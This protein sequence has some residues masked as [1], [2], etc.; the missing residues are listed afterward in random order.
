VFTRTN[1]LRPLVLLMFAALA[2]SVMMGVVLASPAQAETFTVA[3]TNDSGADSLRQAILDANATTDVDKIIFAQDLSGQTIPLAS[4]LPIIAPKS[5]FGALTI[6]A[7]SADITISGDDGVGG[8]VRVF[9]VGSLAELT[10]NN[11]T[12]AN[13]DADAGGGILNFG[14]LTVSNSTLSG[15]SAFMGFGG[16]IYNAGPDSTLTVN[17]STFSRNS[18]T[19]QGGGIGNF[20]GSLEVNNSTF[21]DNS[22][23][24]GGGGIFNA[25][26]ATL[27]NTIVANSPSG[28]NCSGVIVG[29]GNLEWPGNTCG[30][31]F[32][33]G[34]PL[35]GPLADNGGPTQ[36]H[37]LQ[38]GSAAID[39]AVSCPPPATDQRNISRPQGPACDIGSFEFDEP[40]SVKIDQAS[41]QAD[42]T[43]ASPI[44]FTA[45]FNE[46]VTGFTDSDVT[47]SGTAKPT[48]AVVSG[49]PTTFDIAVSGMSSSGTVIASIPANS[50]Q[51]TTGNGNSAST[52]TD[53]TVEFI[54]PNSP[55][56]AADD[57][58][59]TNEDTPLTE[60]APGVLGNDSDSDSGDTL[61][62]ELVS[63]P[64]H[65]TLTLDANGSFS[66]TPATNYHGPDSFTY[67]ATDG[68][69]GEDTATVNITVT[70]VND[71]PVLDAIGNKEVDEGQL[72]SFTAQAT[73]PDNDAISYS[74]VAGENCASGES[75]NVPSGASFDPNTGEFSW[76]PTEQQ[77][78]GTYKLKVKA[79]DNGSPNLSD[80]EQITITV[81]EVNV[82]PELASIGDK[83]VDE[84]QQLSFTAQATDADEPANNITYSLVVGDNC[85]NGETC[86]VPSGATINASTGEFS[87]TPDFTQAGTY[88]LKVKATDDGSPNLSAEEQI[89]ITVKP[90]VDTTAPTVFSVNPS[91]VQTG[92]STTTDITVT[93]SEKMDVSSLN[94]NTVKLVKLGGRR[95][96]PI[97]VVMTT[98]NDLSGRTVL[99]INPYGPG[100]KN[101]AVNTTYELKIEG[102]GDGDNFAV[103][104]LAGNQLAGEVV[105]SFTTA[106][107]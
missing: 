92:V 51:D 57:S 30:S 72:L 82:A 101:L 50:A 18:A 71:A 54:D 22:A 105:S 21:S 67:K 40:P 107:T 31:S 62:A 55:P 6:D 100:T 24:L 49:G 104:D 56:T 25:G 5:D 99:T 63:D 34:D 88:K 102:V 70:P 15:N 9:D 47:L 83:Q 35:L 96:T 12:V 42:P 11:L 97:P 65:G 89:T 1:Y 98:T 60:A 66:Y 84:D 48:T 77:G 79:T 61:T 103:K 53:N 91:D 36:T 59:S 64:S 10:L 43:S 95:P 80:E 46:P 19:T 38:D 17:N 90:V 33:S 37:A 2:A 44:H 52:S 75:C 8:R 26:S 29:G 27:K 13:G 16:G 85:A 81:A 87:W 3:N 28:G 68:N 94:N 14:T 74:L 69:G 86:S 4:P 106:T 41:G 39:A 32:S 58:Y 93:F 45:V 78:P 73:D 23:S 20:F 7:E 76:T